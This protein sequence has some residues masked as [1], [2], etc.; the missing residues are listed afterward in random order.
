MPQ[1]VR[2][3]RT[4]HVLADADEWHAR[5]E[6]CGNGAET[7]MGDDGCH[8]RQYQMV[9][10]EPANRHVR[11]R[12]DGAG[13]QGSPRV[14]STR[15]GSTATA[16]SIGGK[17]AACPCKVVQRL[18]STQGLLGSAS[19][20]ASRRS[21]GGRGFGSVIGPTYLVLAGSGQGLSKP[22][23]TSASTARAWPRKRAFS[24]P[25]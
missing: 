10:D 14:S 7:G 17:A 1:R 25:G 4:D 23:G 9:R 3:C 11:G 24:A 8:A 13:R 6:G 20:P 16:S 15:T 19:K 12:I 22:G 21:S 2:R 5:G 18:S